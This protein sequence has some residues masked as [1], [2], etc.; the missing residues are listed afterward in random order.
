M[1][2]AALRV[3]IRLP[4]PQSLKEK[5]AVLRPVIEGMRRLGSFSVAEVD[6]HDDWQRATVGVAVVA[7]D[8][9]G[10]DMQISKLRRYLDSRLE[11]EVFDVFM[12]ELEKP[13]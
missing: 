3:E 11:I 7:P 8:G 13:E 2:V 12:S 9:R 6:H 1:R 4:T 10:L 5:R